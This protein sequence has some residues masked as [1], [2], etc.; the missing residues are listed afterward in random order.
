[1]LKTLRIPVTALVVLGAVVGAC[2]ADTWTSTDVY[3]KMRSA[4][5]WHIEQGTFYWFI[6]T[7]LGG[8]YEPDKHLWDPTKLGSALAYELHAIALAYPTL[9]R[10]AAEGLLADSYPAVLK[11]YENEIPLPAEEWPKVRDA[12]IEWVL[13]NQLSDG[14]WGYTWTYNGF[15]H[16]GSCTNETA[17]A[18]IFLNRVLQ[19]YEQG[20]IQ[21]PQGVTVDQIA[22]AIKSGVGWLL[23]NQLSDGGW[24]TSKAEAQTSSGWY[25]QMAC[26]A[27]FYTLL[28]AKYLGL[29]QEDVDK[30]KQA[31]DRGIEWILNTQTSDGAFQSGV[32]CSEY[33]P[34]T[35]AYI[36]DLL[37]KVAAYDDALGLG[38]DK[39]R[40]LSAIEKAVQWLFKEGE[41]GITWVQV[42][43]K[44]SYGNPIETAYGPAWAYSEQYLES[45]NSPETTVTGNVLSHALLEL[46]Y[47]GIAT[48]VEVETPGGEVPLKELFDPN[49]KYNVYATIQWLMNQQWCSTL[50]NVAWYGGW[51]WPAMGVQVTSTTATPNPV[52][53]WA[54][55]YAMRAL[56]AFYDPAVYYGTLPSVPTATTQTPTSS[57]GSTSG[58]TSGLPV[59]P[60]VPV[61]RRKS[62]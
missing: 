24:S 2:S 19:E 61:P 47:Y 37:V 31:L 1:M 52:S 25:T 7:T 39:S 5:G 34:D 49:S 22:Q 40:I 56:E 57:T 43:I 8:P 45:Q 60:V 33:S 35:Q 36:I 38:L 21:L 41:S 59:I 62:E 6:P 44:D 11:S 26:W 50:E 55:A 14:G 42:T 10:A 13:D 53:P 51:P 18:V 46:Y 28:N 29:S 27:L 32:M 54:T 58:G 17:E 30:I 15:T 4:V 9:D 20:Q 3:Q 16:T 48:D 23:D 12:C